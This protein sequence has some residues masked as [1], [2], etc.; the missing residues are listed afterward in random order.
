MNVSGSMVSEQMRPP[1]FMIPPPEALIAKTVV[2]KEE[3]KGATSFVQ[4]A[5][6]MGKERVERLN[7]YHAKRMREPVDPTGVMSDY[8]VQNWQRNRLIYCRYG[9]KHLEAMEKR[10]SSNLAS[11]NQPM[12]NLGTASYLLN[13]KKMIEE[14]NKQVQAQKEMDKQHDIEV[15]DF[16][17]KVWTWT[18]QITFLVVSVIGM[19][20]W[21]SYASKGK[22]PFLW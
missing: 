5:R 8:M 17:I 18:W 22:L 12:Q 13:I 1:V 4:I 6:L 19:W 2:T 3:A 16:W 7:A 21:L 20:W 15:H 10:K 9:E 14:H 11:A